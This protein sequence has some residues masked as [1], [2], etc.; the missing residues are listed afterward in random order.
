MQFSYITHIKNVCTLSK[1]H[2]L[3]SK[4]THPHTHLAAVGE[5]WVFAA[6]DPSLQ[7]RMPSLPPCHTGIQ[8][9]S[10][11]HTSLYLFVPLP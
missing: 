8:Q 6:S 7:N 4:L 9:P 2:T 1:T 11:C 3:P 5:D 10:P